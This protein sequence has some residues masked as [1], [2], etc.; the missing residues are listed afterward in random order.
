MEVGMAPTVTLRDVAIPVLGLGLGL[1]SLKQCKH[2]LQLWEPDLCV[3][4]CVLDFAYCVSYFAVAV[5]KHVSQI[6]L[7]NLGEQTVRF[8]LG[9]P[10]GMEAETVEGWYYTG[11]LPGSCSDSFPIQPISTCLGMVLPIVGWCLPYQSSV[12]VLPQ[13]LAIVYLIKAMFQLRFH[14]L[15]TCGLCQVNNKI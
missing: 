4:V 13:S 15:E 10:A 8:N 3:C 11:F 12:K 7:F 2:Y 5:I 9:T 14:F 1:L 6:Q